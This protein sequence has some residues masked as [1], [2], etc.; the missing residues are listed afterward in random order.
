MLNIDTFPYVWDLVDAR[1]VGLLDQA[2]HVY[3]Q[4]G[5]LTAPILPTQSDSPSSEANHNPIR[6]P[7]HSFRPPINGSQKRRVRKKKAVEA[8]I[9]KVEPTV[10]AT[11]NG[12]KQ[13]VSIPAVS[14]A[15]SP[16]LEG[17][18]IHSTRTGTEYA[19]LDLKIDQIHATAAK[20]S[21]E[22]SPTSKGA[23]SLVSSLQQDRPTSAPSPPFSPA[24]KY[25]GSLAPDSIVSLI[26]LPT[27]PSNGTFVNDHVVS[28]S[29]EQEIEKPSSP[30]PSSVTLAPAS[31]D[32]AVQQVDHGNSATGDGDAESAKLQPSK[33]KRRSK[34]GKKTKTKSEIIQPVG[35]HH[36][37]GSGVIVETVNEMNS[38]DQ[39]QNEPTNEVARRLQDAPTESLSSELNRFDLT[40]GKWIPFSDSYAIFEPNTGIGSLQTR[41]PRIER[42]IRQQERILAARA[43]GEERQKQA[44]VKNQARKARR[45][46]LRRDHIAADSPLLRAMERPRDYAKKSTKP[47]SRSPPEKANETTVKA[48]NEY[49][50][51]SGEKEK[52]EEQIRKRKRSLQRAVELRDG[53]KRNAKHQPGS[54]NRDQDHC[55]GFETGTSDNENDTGNDSAESLTQERP[56]S[57][58]AEGSGDQEEEGRTAIFVAK[59]DRRIGS[60]IVSLRIKSKDSDSDH[61][62]TTSPSTSDDGQPSTENALAVGSESLI[63]ENLVAQPGSPTFPVFVPPAEQGQIGHEHQTETME[64]L[65]LGEGAIFGESFSRR[66]AGNE[67]ATGSQ[68][69]SSENA[70]SRDIDPDS[71]PCHQPF[72]QPHS[73]RNDFVRPLSPGSLCVSNTLLTKRIA[74][75]D[76]SEHVQS[77]AEVFQPDVT[78]GPLKNDQRFP[79]SNKITSRMYDHSMTD[80]DHPEAQDHKRALGENQRGRWGGQ[81]GHHSR[82][83]CGSNNRTYH[84]DRA[85]SMSSRAGHSRNTWANAVQESD[86]ELIARRVEQRIELEQHMQATGTTYTDYAGLIEDSYVQ[87]DEQREPVNKTVEKIMYGPSSES[88]LPSDGSVPMPEA[89]NVGY[90]ETEDSNPRDIVSD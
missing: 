64:P 43:E 83:A 32:L 41:T 26:S 46:L 59:V 22:G 44:K 20:A 18:T 57:T 63:A 40:Q 62:E 39:E 10:E 1:S 73:V 68:V 15:Q 6:Q 53:E 9:A 29:A 86:R 55:F 71:R 84:G 54:R 56:E 61:L 45:L 65:G 7:S 67:E 12:N 78:Q 21:A 33:R 76:P 19:T 30:A 38:L 37:T 16:S 49:C 89:A 81:R 27:K 13:V 85:P 4:T 66:I 51:L 3:Q 72:L 35:L 75:E 87:L 11:S 24:H 31:E 17:A 60:H 28:D 14:N 58:A 42:Y 50:K 79:E 80:A 2:Y 70:L 23:S 25:E 34:K 69:K 36:D 8:D 48:Q 47:R 88:L 82:R 90:S 74:G 77:S 52:P 5:S